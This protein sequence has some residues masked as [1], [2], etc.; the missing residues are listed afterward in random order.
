MKENKTQIQAEWG[1]YTL[2]IEG[3]KGYVCESCGS[4]MYAPEEIEMIEKLS[5]ALAESSMQEKLSYFNVGETAELLRVSP[6]TV[7]NML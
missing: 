2:T 1:D 6:K 7:Y 4:K 5:K 3:V